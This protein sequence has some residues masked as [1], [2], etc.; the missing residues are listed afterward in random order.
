M[1][2]YFLFLFLSFVLYLF[3][4]YKLSKDDIIF[5]RKNISLDQLFNLVFL[6]SIIGLLSARLFYVVANPDKGFLNPL[7][8]LLFPYFPGLS[9]VGGVF[10]TVLF[11]IYY[12]RYKKYPIERI[13]DFFVISLFSALP[14]GYIGTMFEKGSLTFLES[15]FLPALYFILFLI[16]Y[17]VFFPRLLQNNLQPGS[18]GTLGLIL[19]SLISFLTSMVQNKMGLIWFIGIPEVLAAVIFFTSLYFLVRKET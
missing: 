3:W 2:I 17:K 18:I 10:G 14:L 11:I 7:V 13:L 6:V 19:F 5:I 8:F 16:M 15:I 4:L 1:Q 9:L 12:G